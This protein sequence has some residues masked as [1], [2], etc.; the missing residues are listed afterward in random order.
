MDKG[1]TV[2]KCVL[3]V[4]PKIPQIPPNLFGRSAQ[5]AKEFRIYLKK[6]FIR[7]PQSVNG[8]EKC[9]MR[10][11]Q[12]Q[13]VHILQQPFNYGHLGKEVYPKVFDHVHVLDQTETIITQSEYLPSF[14][15]LNQFFVYGYSNDFLL[16]II[17]FKR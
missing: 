17:R 2:P 9:A 1:L 4:Q 12:A 15:V 8:Y 7:R 11:S 10:S 13:A 3:I 6:S 5:F 16:H 14:Q